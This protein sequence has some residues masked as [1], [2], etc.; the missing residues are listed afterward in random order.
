MNRKQYNQKKSENYR[1]N[2]KDNQNIKKNKKSNKDE[3]CPIKN[4]KITLDYRED[5]ELFNKTAKK[6]ADAICGDETNCEVKISQIRNFYDKV[7]ELE[8]KAFKKD[9]DFNDI[10]PFVKML[11][12]KVE[13]AKSRKL[14]NNC[15]KD[16][17]NKCINQID[18]KDELRVFKLFFE[19][20][21]GFYKGK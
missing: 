20:V 19:A 18:S 12:S 15:F 16:M 21:I 6:W 4:E 2:S 13:Y 8:Q 5:K 1:R 9:I 14:I 7:L 11:N 3:E 17:M 10:L